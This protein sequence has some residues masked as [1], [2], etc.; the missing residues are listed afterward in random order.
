MT[1]MVNLMED[2]FKC[3]ER[4]AHA[5]QEYTCEW[6]KKMA[7]I[8]S[9]GNGDLWNGS[10]YSV[11]TKVLMEPIEDAKISNLVKKDGFDNNGPVTFLRSWKDKMER[12]NIPKDTFK[13]YSTAWKRQISAVMEIQKAMKANPPVLS[14]RA[15]E[16]LRKSISRYHDKCQNAQEQY[17]RL[18]I[19]EEAGRGQR[20]AVSSLSDVMNTVQ[21]VLK[22]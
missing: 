9:S 18:L 19:M 2:Y 1:M 13:L 3:E 11:I 15:E 5:L 17:R 22:I 21:D 8:S 10:I 12:S 14:F 4:T 20:M 6:T 16:K 7:D